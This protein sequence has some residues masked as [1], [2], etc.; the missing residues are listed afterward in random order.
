[1]T[2]NTKDIL[3]LLLDTI[4]ALSRANSSE[5]SLL[6][7]NKD[8]LVKIKNE[9]YDLIF[10]KP[11]LETNDNVIKSLVGQLPFVL[12]DKKKFPTNNDI[13]KFG[14]KT[15]SLS[16]PNWE[17]KSREEIIGRFIVQIT[18]KKTLELSVFLFAWEEFNEVKKSTKKKNSYEINFVDAWLN[19]FDDYKK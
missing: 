4:E 17:K 8:V 11:L 14:E 12:V 15:L 16:I 9:I 1:M 19:F 10:P 7:V 13:I 2:S 3:F 5:K 18:T 6:T